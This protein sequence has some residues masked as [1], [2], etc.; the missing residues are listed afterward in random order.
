[1]RKVKMS[2]LICFVDDEETG[3]W[4][5]IMMQNGDY[6][7]VEV[8]EEAIQVK[9]SKDG[10]FGLKMYEERDAEKAKQLANHFGT[11]LSN[12]APEEMHHPVLKP[13]VNT[14][15]HCSSLA[16]VTWILNTNRT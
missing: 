1:M 7:W 12:I 4:A 9:H 11:V 15:L 6:C 3:G 2:K 13:L 14:V 10:F 8:S 5:R 16:E